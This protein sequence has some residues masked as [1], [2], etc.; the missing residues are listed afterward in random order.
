MAPPTTT[1][2][3]TTDLEERKRVKKENTVGGLLILFRKIKID[4]CLTIIWGR[5]PAVRGNNRTT[6]NMMVM[7]MMIAMI[8]RCGHPSII[9]RA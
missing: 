2:D 3:L 9:M 1:N 5:G 6:T 8:R 7:M 4:E